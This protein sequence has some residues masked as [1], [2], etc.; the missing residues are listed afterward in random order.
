MPT[1]INN[2]NIANNRREN[3][4]RGISINMSSISERF[5]G[6]GRPSSHSISKTVL[7][8]DRS[9][10]RSEELTY[11]VSANLADEPFVSFL[12]TL[13]IDD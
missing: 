6:V 8:Y 3:T 4:K 12:S 11:S 5:L 1:P 10:Q 13:A 2:N 7:Y 9:Q